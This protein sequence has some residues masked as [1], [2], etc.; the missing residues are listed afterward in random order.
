MMA[1]DVVLFVGALLFCV[2]VVKIIMT[3]E[4]AGL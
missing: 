4:Q 3:D 2:L 1:P